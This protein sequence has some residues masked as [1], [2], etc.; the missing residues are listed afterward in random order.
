VY[1]FDHQ[2]EEV[3]S[4]VWEAPDFGEIKMDAEANSYQDDFA[5]V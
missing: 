5:G 3:R 2:S 1:L 4:M